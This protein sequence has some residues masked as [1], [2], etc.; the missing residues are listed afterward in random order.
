MKAE[1]KAK[2]RVTLSICGLG[3]LDESEL[4]TVRYGEYDQRSES[5][6]AARRVKQATANATGENVSPAIPSGENE[7]G[8][9]VVTQDNYREVKSH[10]GQA[11]GNLLGRKVGELHSNVIKWLHDVWRNRLNPS[12]TDQDMRL[13]AAIE[14]A[15]SDVIEKDK[16]AGDAADVI[17]DQ[18]PTVNPTEAA[19]AA[20]RDLRERIQDLVLT[21][22]QAIGY[23]RQ[24]GVFAAG[25]TQ[26][27]HAPESIL[28]YLS[29]P[30]GWDTF[31]RVVEA[32]VKPKPVAAKA[33][34][35]R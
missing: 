10:V 20:T 33:K 24:Q 30:E 11:S 8:P 14:L 28:L 16:R 29:T 22:D 1:T 4:E 6:I 5:E 9:L 34:K 35:K 26:L 3:M 19:K 21:E 17:T 23:L 13:K 7:Y 27:E 25:W 31:K 15:Y 2:R 12:S 32:D 18:Q